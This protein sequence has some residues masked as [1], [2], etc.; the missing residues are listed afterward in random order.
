M[1]EK[2]VFV[3]AFIVAFTLTLPASS[4]LIYELDLGSTV[5][6][7]GGSPEALTGTFTWEL[8]SAPGLFHAHATELSFQSESFTFTLNTT[9]YNNLDSALFPDGT[10]F[11]GEVVDATGLSL[12]T[13]EISSFEEGYY[14]GPINGPTNLVLPDVVIVDHSGGPFIGWIDM[15]ATL[16]PEPATVLLFGLGGLGLLR[17]RRA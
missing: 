5:T 2:S 7:Q 3:F 10:C 9:P 14:T 12:G 11:F 16:V 15:S 6:V 1:R 4:E 8:S 17:K 13:V